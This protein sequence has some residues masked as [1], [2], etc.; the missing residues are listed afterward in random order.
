[1]KNQHLILLSFVLLPFFICPDPAAADQARLKVDLSQAIEQALKTSEDLRIKT[2]DIQKRDAQYREVKSEIYPQIDHNVS[3]SSNFEYPTSAMLTDDYGISSQTTFS[4][5]LWAFGKVSAAIDA[6][7]K[8]IAISHFDQEAAQRDVIYTAKVSYYAALLAQKNYNILEQSYLNSKQNKEIMTN[9]SATG[10]MSKRDN[11]KIASDIATRKPKVNDART[12]LESSLKILKRVMGL[13]PD[14]QIRLVQDFADS[15]RPLKFEDLYQKMI[16]N[17]PTLKALEQNVALRSDLL[18]VKKAGFYPELSMFANWTYQGSDGQA[19]IS[20]DLIDPYGVVGVKVSIPI[21]EGGK[22]AHQLFQARIDKST[23]QISYEK[24]K[25]DFILE[26]DNTMSEYNQYL[27]TLKA[28]NASVELA[29]ESFKLSQDLLESGQVSLTDL[30]DTELILTNEKLSRQLTLYN[31][32][33][34][35]AKIEKLTDQ[36]QSDRSK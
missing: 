32:N 35:L 13:V 15:Y 8:Y 3:W 5:L 21:W 9:R 33:L 4:Q 2:N 22:K 20:G 31:I 17:E 18:K 6:A 29:E 30:N 1:M 27:N 25:K 24:S 16:T 26:L 19:D 11:I 23:A 36:L 28:N 12:S 7:N 10:R 34:A 14:K